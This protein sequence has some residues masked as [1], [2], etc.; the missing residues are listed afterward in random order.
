MM[1][2]KPDH[3]QQPSGPLST[4]ALAT[5]C[6]QHSRF[7]HSPSSDSFKAGCEGLDDDYFLRDLPT[8]PSTTKHNLDVVQPNGFDFSNVL[9]GN[10]YQPPS[11][12][13]SPHVPRKLHDYLSRY[14]S[15]QSNSNLSYA[16]S[17]PG[18]Q[19]DRYLT[20]TPLTTPGHLDSYQ[21]S[22]QDFPFYSNAIN[23]RRMSSTQSPLDSLP[24]DPQWVSQTD[25]LKPFQY[26]PIQDR[27]WLILGDGSL[28]HGRVA[29]VTG[30]YPMLSFTNDSFNRRMT[31]ELVSIQT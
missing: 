2:S 24:E 28:S 16:S 15:T 23:P 10:P 17:T 26:P 5:S 6:E 30:I 27:G 20:Q 14:S 25:F 9:R 4:F 22:S 31:E 7:V 13:T 1:A 8:Q 12:P 21:P 11:S 3:A 18:S 29:I 19:L